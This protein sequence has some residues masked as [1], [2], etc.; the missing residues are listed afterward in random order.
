MA[1]TTHP[2]SGRISTAARCYSAGDTN[3]NSTVC[4]P[5]GSHIV[6]IGDSVMRFQYLSLAFALRHGR[7]A[8]SGNKLLGE[9]KISNYSEMFSRSSEIIGDLCDCSRQGISD[10]KDA[11]LHTFENRYFV[12]GNVRLTYFNQFGRHPMKGAWWPTA[13]VSASLPRIQDSEYAPTWQ[14]ELDVGLERLLPAIAKTL[15]SITRVVVN[16]GG[17]HLAYQ[18]QV[19]YHG[20]SPNISEREL[21]A[22]RHAFDVAGLG[23]VVWWKTYTAMLSSYGPTG[24]DRIGDHAYFNSTSGEEATR[25]IATH[26][27]QVYDAFA[28]TVNFT[29]EAY[30]NHDRM[31]FTAPA[32]NR[33]N[34]MLV[35]QLF[36]E[37][38]ATTAC[39]SRSEKG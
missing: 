29:K 6:F 7:E 22:W 24:G 34:A 36:P 8:S 17:Y 10:H 5:G 35:A 3:A 32:N 27:P 9:Q 16:I 26:F 31:H 14:Y 33:L 23:G 1:C 12:A 2:N 25:I 38:D 15:G 11:W 4:V 20:R 21:Q 18:S 39:D 37:R 19:V 13:N 28:L 30:L